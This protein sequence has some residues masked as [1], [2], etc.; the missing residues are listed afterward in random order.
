MAEAIIINGCDDSTYITEKDWGR[1]FTQDEISTIM[2][3]CSLSEQISTY[4]CMPTVEFREL[5]KYEMEDLADDEDDYARYA[6]LTVNDIKRDND[7]PKAMVVTNNTFETTWRDHAPK[8]DGVAIYIVESFDEIPCNIE[9][10]VYTTEH[11]KAMVSKDGEWVE[12]DNG[13]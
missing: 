1:A 11:A 5:S 9:Q 3:I 13:H 12:V 2:K 10:W 4:Q 6:E 7:T 8:E